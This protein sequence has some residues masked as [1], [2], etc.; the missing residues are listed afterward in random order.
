VDL[1][2]EAPLKRK[3][4]LHTG[5]AT[6]RIGQTGGISPKDSLDRGS[7][8]KGKIPFSIDVKRG[9]RVIRGMVTGVA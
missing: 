1:Q 6:Q 9:E 8:P 2:E 5:G 4:T 7:S 3:M